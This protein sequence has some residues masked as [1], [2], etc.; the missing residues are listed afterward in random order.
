MN[1]FEQVAGILASI[2]N[3]LLVFWDSLIAVFGDSIVGLFGEILDFGLTVTALLPFPSEIANFVIPSPGP[4][5]AFLYHIGLGEAIA[6]FGAAWMLK[7]M[8][9]LT[10]V[11]G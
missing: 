7:L 10:I 4:A 8:L 1:V 6:L 3:F 9:K 11:L 5:G 2:W